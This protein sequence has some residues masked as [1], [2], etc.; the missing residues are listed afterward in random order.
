MKVSMKKKNILKSLAFFLLLMFNSH[1]W[2][3]F[4]ETP[5][6]NPL[7]SFSTSSPSYQALNTILIKYLKIEEAGGWKQI[8]P[9][10]PNTHEAEISF[11]DELKER[12]RVEGDLSV[13]ENSSE[14]YEEAIK[15]FQRR[16]GIKS[17]G[18]VG[19]ETLLKLNISVQEKITAI[20]LNM[21]RRQG[22]LEE[23]ENP[24]ISVNIPDFSLS[25]VEDN[26][27]VLSMK[28]IVGRE[29]RE[30][31]V[32][33]AKMQYIVINPYWHV[34]IT[35]LREDIIPK[36]RKDIRYLK[37]ER[38]KIFRNGDYAGKKAINPLKINWKKA[39]ADT[40]P[41]FL[42]QEPSPK[43]V[44]G[45]LKFIFP[46]PEDIY[47]HDTPIK[48][49]FD[50]N[51]RTFSSGC[52][53]IQEPRKLA[54]YLLKNDEN[55]WGYENID[56][57]IAKSHNKTIPLSTPV[58]VHLHYWTVWADDDGMANFRSDV[59]GY[60]EDLA[61]SLGWHRDTNIR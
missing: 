39:N 26:K 7:S 51:I 8:P 37:K 27:T 52:I 61:E 58:K 50:K 12:L 44:L 45:R 18:R 60:D 31:P 56:A 21:E 53:R 13:D 4:S 25:V 54:H 6:V 57:L 35:I 41:Y 14:A 22:I 40:F 16:H 42:R 48:S 38:I 59:Y 2:A 3:D 10:H 17:D 43:N 55:V 46:N 20:R 29:G 19:E 9:S 5:N 49:L 33:N 32:F 23:R 28:A 15:N 36:V 47:I 34:P 1:L 11:V 24:Y 30:T